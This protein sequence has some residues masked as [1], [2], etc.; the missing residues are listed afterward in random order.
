MKLFTDFLPIILFFIAYKIHGIYTA[1]EV[2][3]VAA[4]ILMAWQWWRHG[5]IETMTWV[6]TLLILIFGGLT[7][8][9][10]NDT[11]IKVKP[12]ILYLLFAGVLLFTH[13]RQKPLLERLMG[14]QLPATLPQSF[15]RRLNAY[16]IIFFLF[17]AILN[18]VVA[19]SFS[20]GIWV[21]YKL[22][23]MLGITIIFVLFQAVLISRALPQEV[24]DGDS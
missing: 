18:L 15:W 8:Y 4:I 2:L 5:R 7:L 14:G 3:I 12:S 1:T 19:Y 9:F 21:D 16:W 6:S 11:F 17:S 10:H 20:T 24:K 22:F 13:W 23:G